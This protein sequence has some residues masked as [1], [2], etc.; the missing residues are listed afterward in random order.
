MVAAVKRRNFQIAAA[1]AALPLIARAED[2][3]T[4]IERSSGGRLG[5]AVLHPDGRFEGH[6]LD[7]R[8]PMCSTF[9]WLAAAHVLH[10]VDQG[11]ER[12]DRRIRFGADELR[13]HSPVTAKHV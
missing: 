2:A 9:K 4:P 8:F 12:L 1:L 3:W 13:A 5:V 10:R 7:E 6:R 11:Q